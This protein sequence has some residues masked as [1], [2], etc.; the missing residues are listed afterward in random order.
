LWA[1]DVAAW[2]P[3]EEVV[4]GREAGPAAGVWLRALGGPGRPENAVLVTG[5][6]ASSLDVGWAL[7]EAGLLA[8]FASVLAVSQRQG[9]GQLRRDW[10]SPPGNL[11]A[12]LAWPSH[13]GD[14]GSMAPVLV[15]HCLAEALSERGFTV[16]VKWPNDLL[17]SDGKMGGIL[18][19][20]RGGRTLAGIG[21]NCASAPDA[22]LLRRDHAAPATAL[23]LFGEVPGAIT[24]WAG[25]VQH[26]QTCYRQCVTVS[27]SGE[28][29][30]LVAR[31]L[32]WLGREIFVR[33]N[34]TNAFQARIV[35]LAEDGGLRLCRSENRPGLELTLHC[36]S[37]SLL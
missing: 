17:L 23:A 11:Y 2:G 15:G 10:T 18:L 33:E 9:R 5:E 27:D 20:E 29:A 3:W 35:G 24:C 6:C 19:E 22:A 32:A 13:A 31:H 1:A 7:A 30:R 37:I 36:G 21:L 14:L 34:D 16:L 28:R 4:L 8:P 12:A 25:L 26:G